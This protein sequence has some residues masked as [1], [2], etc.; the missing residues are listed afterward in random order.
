MQKLNKYPPNINLR[1]INAV[2]HFN[3]P[4]DKTYMT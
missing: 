1:D 4:I 2:S 3:K